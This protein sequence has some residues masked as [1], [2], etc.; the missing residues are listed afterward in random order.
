[1]VTI[2]MLPNN[3][4]QVLKKQLL[5]VIISLNL[6]LNLFIIPMILKLYNNENV[7]TK[8]EVAEI[9]KLHWQ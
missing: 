9:D 7:E 3:L 6:S 1:M 5:T 4:D 8:L 2:Y